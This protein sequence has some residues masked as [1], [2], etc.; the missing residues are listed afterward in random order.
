VPVINSTNYRT[1]EYGENFIHGHT[2]CLCACVYYN[3]AK[4][5]FYSSKRLL[6]HLFQEPSFYVVPGL[7]YEDRYKLHFII[8]TIRMLLGRPLAGSLPF[9]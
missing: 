7:R 4:E 8:G 9:K 2:C 6:S 1:V 5:L 3:S